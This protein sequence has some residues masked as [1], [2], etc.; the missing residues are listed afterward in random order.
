MCRDNP[1]NETVEDIVTAR[2]SIVVDKMNP[3][4]WD[5]YDH[6]RRSNYG[7]ANFQDFVSARGDAGVGFMNR[8]EAEAAYAADPGHAHI[9]GEWPVYVWLS[10]VES[11]DCVECEALLVRAIG[12][13]IRS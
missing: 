2:I 7:E 11:G 13:P 5:K 1:G 3:W 10:G 6:R 12:R 8:E 9:V 4:N